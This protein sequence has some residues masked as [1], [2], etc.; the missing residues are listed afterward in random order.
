MSEILSQAEI[1]A[2]LSSLS[3]SDSGPAMPDGQAKPGAGIGGFGG[4][5]G[6]GT[7]AGARSA[8]AYEVYDFRRPD[9]FSK[10]QLRTLQMLHETFGRLAGTSLSAYLRS[11]VNIDLISLEQVPYEEYLRSIN[12]SAFTIM[13]IPPL[14]GQAALEVEFGLV[15]SMIDKLLGGPGRSLERSMLTDIEQPLFHNIVDRMFGALK[16]AWEGVVIVN[17]SIEAIETSAQFVQI[18]PPTDIVVSILF[19]VRMGET[20][21][22]M[23]LCI[24]YMVLKPITTKLSAQKWFAASASRK[25]TLAHRR[26]L[27]SSLND[28]EVSCW[29]RLGRSQITVSDFIRLRQGDV[30]KLDQKVARDIEFLV[31]NTPKFAVRPALSGKKLAFQVRR[32]LNEE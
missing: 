22:A 12:Q 1:E 4:V 18:A 29:G 27:T 32:R 6:A 5:G 10:E 30:I 15:F 26:A 21:G 14:S 7:K 24:P 23:S 13:S 9:K 11:T 2:L 19:E 17:P 16:A 3:D 25:Q 8:V 31:A 20:H 28:T